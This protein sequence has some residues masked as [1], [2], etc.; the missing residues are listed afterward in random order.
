MYS[1]QIC[2]HARVRTCITRTDQLTYCA[3]LYLIRA[4]HSLLVHVSAA[5][6]KSSA[7]AVQRARGGRGKKTSIES[8]QQNYKAKTAIAM[9]TAPTIA[10]EESA[11]V[12]ALL[13]SPLYGLARLIG[14]TSTPASLH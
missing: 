4:R 3:L 1:A 12:T 5:R 2:D 7:V 8:I 6:S 13:L 14:V 10:P 11:M 9:P